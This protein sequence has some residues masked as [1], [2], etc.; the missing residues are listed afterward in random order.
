MN[1]TRLFGNARD[2]V[3]NSHGVK[4]KLSAMIFIPCRGGV[5][6]RTDEYAA[7]E[8]IEKGVRLLA[9]T[10]RVLCV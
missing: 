8:Q 4:H 6:H 3:A 2:A 9:E 7:P 1:A 10:L 5:S